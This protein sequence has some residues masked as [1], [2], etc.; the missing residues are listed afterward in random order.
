MVGSEKSFPHPSSLQF[1]HHRRRRP[2]SSSIVKFHVDWGVGFGVEQ[3]LERCA[4]PEGVKDE[5][6]RWREK[7]RRQ[8]R[9]K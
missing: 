9:L 5:R 1:H 4:E 6:W 3:L 7:M 2:R 8:S